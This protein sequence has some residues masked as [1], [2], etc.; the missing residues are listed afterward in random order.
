MRSLSLFLKCQHLNSGTNLLSA[1]IRTGSRFKRS[2]CF[3]S[4]DVRCLRVLSAVRVPH[5]EDHCCKSYL[6][7]LLP[8][9]DNEYWFHCKS[10]P[11]SREGI[12]RNGA[13]KLDVINL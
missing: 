8:G 9:N 6:S 12:A 10:V 7:E 13:Q 4:I 5:V 2:M 11:S 3:V 1:R